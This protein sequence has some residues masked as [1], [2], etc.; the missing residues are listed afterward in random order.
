MFAVV[1]TDIDDKA[2]HAN[3]YRSVRRYTLEICSR[4]ET[5]DYIVQ[6]TAE[7]SPPKWHLGHT[8]WFFEE[9]ILVRFLPEYIRFNEQYRLLFNSYYKAAGKHWLQGDR[10]MLSRPTVPEIQAYRHYVDKYILEFLGRGALQSDVERVLEIGLHHEQQHQE[11]LYMDIKFILGANPLLPAYMDAPLPNSEVVADKWQSRQEG[12]YEIGHHEEGFA[13]DNEGPQH[14]TYIQPHHICENTVTNGDFLAFIN[15]QVYA[16]PKYWLSLGWDW[17][18]DNDIQCPFYW[19]KE[20]EHWYEFTL[21]GLQPL[22]LNAPVTHV[23]YFEA[24]AFARWKGTRLPTEQE[25][26]IYLSKSDAKPLS[27]RNNRFHPCN[28]S[29]LHSQVWCWTSSHYSPY[30]GYRPFKG[31]LEE[32]NGKFMCNQFVLKGG[33]IAT[34]H[35]HYRHTYR[36]FFQPHQRWMFSGIRLAKDSE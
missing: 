26:E 17:V 11:L 34:P 3:R 12:I 19:K 30:P 29:D 8:T 20:G 10:G 32:Y 21:H 1:N 2:S 27:E 6:P 23:S 16:A 33:C 36:N 14:K 18:E 35:G 5:D 22:D 7:V 4:L 13:Y 25:L 31:M 24:D 9:L 15:D 28:S